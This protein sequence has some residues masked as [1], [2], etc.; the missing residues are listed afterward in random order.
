MPKTQMMKDKIV[1]TAQ[2]LV[3]GEL[4]TVE[5]GVDNAI[6]STKDA[7]HELRNEADDI[8][9]R[10]FGRFKELWQDQQPKVEKYIAS[11]PWLVLGGFL[12]VGYLI[13]GAR[14]RSSRTYET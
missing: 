12:L 1:G 14:E 8:I 2:Q 9:D 10:A 3:N 7:V 4:D 13:A 11:H 5:G 6:D